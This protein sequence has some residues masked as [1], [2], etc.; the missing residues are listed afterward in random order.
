VWIPEAFK[1]L[2]TERTWK[3]IKQFRGIPPKARLEEDLTAETKE[4]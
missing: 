2:Q 4:G 1:G 3:N